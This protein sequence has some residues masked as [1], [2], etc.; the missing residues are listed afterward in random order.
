[1]IV[2]L[3]HVSVGYHFQP[4]LE[5]VSFALPKGC[6]CLIQGPNASG[7]TTLAKL[8][9]GLLRPLSG[10]KIISYHQPAYVPQQNPMDLQYPLTLRE[11]IGMGRKPS[12][13]FRGKARKKE[14]KEKIEEYIQLVDLKGSED[15]LFREASGGQ[16]QRALIARSFLS[17]PDFM[18][19]DEPFSH[20]DGMGKKKIS[21]FLRKKNETEGISFCLI[22]H[23]N[24]VDKGFYTH[25]IEISKQ[26]S[27]SPQRV[28]CKELSSKV[29]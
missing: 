10:Q 3:D 25:L 24:I 17:S 2:R 14:E 9:L 11:L 29:L 12:I 28:V 19:L 5:Q 26:N 16:L 13:F 21:S 1:M 8:M 27:N 7:K 22:D 23:I 6:I 4:I 15:L 20:L 18:I